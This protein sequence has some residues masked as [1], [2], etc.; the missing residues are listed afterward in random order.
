MVL[1]VAE[2]LISRCVF[3]A[4]LDD[5]SCRVVDDLMVCVGV[6]VAELLISWCVLML[7][8]LNC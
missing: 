8:W 7:W 2:L 4:L 1:L 6:L 5:L 3:D